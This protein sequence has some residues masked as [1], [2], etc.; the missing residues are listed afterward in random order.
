MKKCELVA[1]ICK[2]YINLSECITG[3]DDYGS[4][5]EALRIAQN[6]DQEQI[7]KMDVEGW[8]N[9]HLDYIAEN[10]EEYV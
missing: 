3:Y 5:E 1:A 7:C 9:P 10:F 8:K 4:L 6:I 2:H